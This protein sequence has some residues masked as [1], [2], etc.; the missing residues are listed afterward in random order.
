[1]RIVRLCG[2]GVLALGAAVL[3]G[4]V[5]FWYFDLGVSFLSRPGL[6]CIVGVV[7]VEA[8]VAALTIL[9]ADEMHGSLTSNPHSPL[10]Q[11][12]R[13]KGTPRPAPPAARSA[14]DGDWER[15]SEASDKMGSER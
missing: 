15:P 14:W 6:G 11:S 5:V 8:V 9:K 10:G 12:L 2:W 4:Y 1:M 3:Q 7:L 13:S